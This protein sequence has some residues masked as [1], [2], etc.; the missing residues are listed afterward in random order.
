MKRASLFLALCVSAA[1]QGQGQKV[2]RYDLKMQD[3]KYVYGPAQPVMRLHSGDTV[4]T[5]P[6]TPKVTP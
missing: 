3:L 6:W 1:A 2:L 4:D 5:I